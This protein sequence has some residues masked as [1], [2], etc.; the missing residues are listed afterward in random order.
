MHSHEE[1]PPISKREDRSWF[2]RGGMALCLIALIGC[3]EQVAPTTNA[4]RW[5]AAADSETKS[6]APAAAGGAQPA[7]EAAGPAEAPVPP[8]M[9]RKI[10]Y[11][12]QV[13]LIVESMTA[14][15]D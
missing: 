12:A 7:A 15:A 9:P 8:A 5:M 6:I 4:R 1:R 13:E 3:A 11:N 10:I 2:R 14:T